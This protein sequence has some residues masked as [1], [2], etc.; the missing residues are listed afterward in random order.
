MTLSCYYCA[1]SL[2]NPCI[3]GEG[4]LKTRPP[5]IHSL[6]LLDTIGQSRFTTPVYLAVC[7]LWNAR[8][9]AL[10]FTLLALRFW[11][12]NHTSSYKSTWLGAMTQHPNESGWKREL[13]K[14]AKERELCFLEDRGIFVSIGFFV[15]FFQRPPSLLTCLLFKVYMLHIHSAA[16]C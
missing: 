2:F 14:K 12:H 4:D 9:S 7:F 1:G 8:L 11:P 16:P 15:V 3:A 6:S 13:R 10:L 5:F